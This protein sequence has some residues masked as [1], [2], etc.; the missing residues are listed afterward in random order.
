MWEEV[1]S[2]PT[3]VMERLRVED[4]WLYRNR[5]VVDGSAQSA[6]GYL[7]TATLAYVPDAAKPGDTLPIG[8]DKPIDL[9]KS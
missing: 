4:G 2:E 8:D 7:W 5:V 3:D 6:G 9:P 1:Y